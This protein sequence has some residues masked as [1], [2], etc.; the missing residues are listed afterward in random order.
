MPELPE[1]ETTRRG[2]AT[3]LEG[4]TLSRVA[5]LVPALRFPPD[6]SDELIESCLPEV[7]AIIGQPDLP[8]DTPGGVAD[9]ELA[10]ELILVDTAGVLFV[11]D[12]YV[13]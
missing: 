1:V 3:T 11:S 4:H 9:A 8:A 12:A 2:L 5:A 6:P 13:A 7:F 10:G